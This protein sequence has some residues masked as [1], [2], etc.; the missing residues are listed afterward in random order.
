LWD[1]PLQAGES[2]QV[3]SFWK[4][5]NRSQEGIKLFLHLLDEDGEI[6]AQHDGLDVL[7]HGLQPG[8]ELVQ[9]HTAELPDDLAPGDYGLQIGAYSADDFSRLRLPDERSDRILLDK[10]R[11]IA[12]P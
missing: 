8:D 7:M 12:A 4:V 9:L 2:L 10:Y 6:V 3:L 1:G 11:V 5:T